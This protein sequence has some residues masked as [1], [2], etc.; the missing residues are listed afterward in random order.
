M[1]SVWFISNA[2]MGEKSTWSVGPKHWK[3]LEWC[4]WWYFI[5]LDAKGNGVNDFQIVL[6]HQN[7][8]LWKPWG[9]GVRRRLWQGLK[10]GFPRPSWKHW[11]WNAVACITSSV[12]FRILQ[13][14]RVSIVDQRFL[15]S[16]SRCVLMIFQKGIWK[17]Y[18]HNQKISSKK[19]VFCNKTIKR[20]QKVRYGMVHC[21]Y[22]SF[23]LSWHCWCHLACA[24]SLKSWCSPE[25][26]ASNKSR[27]VGR[28]CGRLTRNKHNWAPFDMNFLHGKY[29]KCLQSGIKL[30]AIIFYLE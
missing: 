12:I 10:R 20:I 24:F 15:L 1:R 13:L 5:Q 6:K 25:P 29:I 28:G 9:F 16:K 30:C 3:V 4:R 7:Q 18:M 21:F 11:K 8:Q 23:Q 26:W 27:R 22:T 17:V 19:N 2:E 14:L